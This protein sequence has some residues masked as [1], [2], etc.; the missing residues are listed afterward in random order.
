MERITDLII[1][2]RKLFLLLP[3]AFG[4]LCCRII[5]C[6]GAVAGIGFGLDRGANLVSDGHALPL[7]FVQRLADHPLALPFRIGGPE[8]GRFGADA[9]GFLRKR[10][11]RLADQRQLL[12]AQFHVSCEP[13]RCATRNLPETEDVFRPERLLTDLVALI[14][15]ED[16]HAAAIGIPHEEADVALN[17]AASALEDN[18]IPRLRVLRRRAVVKER[19]GIELART[20]QPIGGEHGIDEGRA[21]GGHLRIDVLVRGLE[22]VRQRSAL[23]R[24]IL[25]ETLELLRGIDQ[26]LSDIIRCL[27]PCLGEFLGAILDNL[28]IVCGNGI[29]GNA[30]ADT[31]TA[32]ARHRTAVVFLVVGRG[33]PI[34]QPLDLALKRV[35][36]EAE[37]LRDVAEIERFGLP[38]ANLP[39]K[40]FA[41][42]FDG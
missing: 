32:T 26:G 3:Q 16:A 35:V 15:A 39:S 5:G 30:A 8:H 18:E 38:F 14:A 21:P 12:A 29:L 11:H 31:S 22:E 1:D 33:E 20:R 9:G 10:T 27:C 19:A 34:F 23:C 6:D 25:A 41:L 28:E 7:Q 17:V 37:V 36:C 2:G 40:G 13:F 42:V 24:L 4:S